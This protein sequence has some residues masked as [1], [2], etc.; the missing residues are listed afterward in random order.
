[1]QKIIFTICI[2][3]V[4]VGNSTLLFGGPPVKKITVT[5]VNTCEWDVPVGLG[6]DVNTW[7][8]DKKEKEKLTIKRIPAN[9]SVVFEDIQAGI[10]D[11]TFVVFNETTN[12]S[13][14]NTWEFLKDTLITVTYDFD[15]ME[16]NWTKEEK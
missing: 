15:E 8:F 12:Y 16:Y 10:K 1:M 14:S 9:G 4:F 13:Q 11:W 5:V 2:M 7:W 3:T 6:R